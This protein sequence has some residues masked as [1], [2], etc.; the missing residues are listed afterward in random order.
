LENKIRTTLTSAV[1]VPG[2][3]TREGIEVGTRWRL[4]PELT[5]GGAYTLLDAVDADGLLEAR[6]AKHSGRL[7]LTYIPTDG[8][9]RFNVTALYNGRA[10]DDAFRVLFHDFGF[11]A[12]APESVFLDDYLLLSAAASY[13]V[14]PGMELFGRVENILDEDYQE[15]FGFATPG[16]A[17]YAGVRFTYEEPLTAALK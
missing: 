12:L 6:R 1:N 14:R 8:R 16:V 17:A 7:D 9:A 4:T 10:R 11:P 2:E 5:L 3:S 15:V 13:K